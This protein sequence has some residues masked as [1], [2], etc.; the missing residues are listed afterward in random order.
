MNKIQIKIKNIIPTSDGADYEEIIKL[1]EMVG[2][3]FTAKPLEDTNSNEVKLSLDVSSVIEKLNNLKEENYEA[4]FV[5]IE[6]ENK[7]QSLEQYFE[8]APLGAV[9]I[10]CI[11]G[12]VNNED[13]FVNRFLDQLF[14]A[15]NLTICGSCNLFG[16]EIIGEKQFP[17]LK[18]SRTLAADLFENA[19]FVNNNWKWPPLAENEYIS[20]WNWLERQ[21]IRNFSLAKTPVQKACSIILNLSQKGNI[22]ASD[23]IGISQVFEAFFLTKDEP[24][25]KGLELK[26]NSIFSEPMTEKKWVKKFYSLR[27]S[28]AHGDHEIL[29]PSY[30]PDDCDRESEDH[31]NNYVNYVEKGFLVIM[32]ILKDLASHGKT[33]YS[34]AYLVEMKRN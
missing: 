24:K 33:N 9:L 17:F 10:I 3:Y 28:I 18:T 1:W 4:Y 21:N 2:D 8:F 5:R 31:H 27:S 11:D 20:T 12:Q 16:Y 6:K 25:T 19:I 13:E 30:F 22:E 29:R 32:A 23:V 7:F 15:M 14:I 34:F 26:L